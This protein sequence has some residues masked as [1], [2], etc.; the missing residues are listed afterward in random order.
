M[1]EP[2]HWRVRDELP[3]PAAASLPLP[4][5]GLPAIASAFQPHSPPALEELSADVA[6]LSITPAEPCDKVL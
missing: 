2:Q 4:K 6:S 1:E 3:L 5:G